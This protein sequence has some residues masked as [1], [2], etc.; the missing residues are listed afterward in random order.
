MRLSD[1]LGIRP[2]VTAVIGGG[3]KTT[4]ISTLAEELREE[5]TVI[6]C[7]STHIRVPGRYPL[8]TGGEDELAEAL[9][10]HGAVCAGTPAGGG[11]LTAP[12]LSFEKL[13]ELADHVLVEAD[14]SKGLPLKRHAS[15]EPVIPANAGR[16]VLVVGADG[17]NKP[18]SSVC[19]RAS[20]DETEAATPAWAAQNI[21][22]EGLGDCVYINKV[23]NDGD[24]AAALELAALLDCPVTAGSLLRKDYKCI[25]R[26]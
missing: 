18:V 13:A 24:Y 3:G 11:K 5:S 19:H 23:E 8:V 7:T 20:E 26:D 14:G 4:L 6:V 1:C 10:I 9:R 16:V 22:R 17:F 15:H 2:G 12:P 25:R 21:L